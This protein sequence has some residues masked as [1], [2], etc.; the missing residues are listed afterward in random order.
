MNN[1]QGEKD[2]EEQ[3]RTNGSK[4]WISRISGSLQLAVST[5]ASVDYKKIYKKM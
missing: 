5:V 4:G 3:K 1:L 2:E